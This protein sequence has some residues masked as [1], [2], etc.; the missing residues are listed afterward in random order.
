MMGN[1]LSQYNRIVCLVATAIALAA[2]TQDT[3][4]INTHLSDCKYPMTFTTVVQQPLSATTPT[5]VADADEGAAIGCSWSEGDKISVTVNALSDNFSAHTSCTLR[6]DGSVASYDPQIFWHTTGPHSVTAWYSN[7]S[8]SHTSDNAIDISDQSKGLAYVLK[9]EPTTHTYYNERSTIALRFTHQLAKVRVLLT[10]DGGNA[11]DPS[12]A[13]VE[14]RQCYTACAISDGDITPT[15]NADGN[16]KMMP[17]SYAGGYFEANV[18]PDADGTIR[19][20]HAMNFI[21]SRKNTTINLAQP[22]RFEKGKV[23]TFTIR[24]K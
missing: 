14:I 16:V 3:D 7:I 2:C 5:R 21:S 12:T 8:D 23:Y 1:M 4:N 18:I 15:G 13:T 24:V 9:S 10:D 19:Q 22:V 17:P 20:T 11:I 6:A